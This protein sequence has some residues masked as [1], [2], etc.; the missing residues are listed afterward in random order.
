MRRQ[1]VCGYNIRL[2]LARYI[3]C[4]KTLCWHN[5]P[6]IMLLLIVTSL[7]QHSNAHVK[8][9]YLRHYGILNKNGP[10]LMKPSV[11]RLVNK[12]LLRLSPCGR[13][14]LLYRSLRKKLNVCYTSKVISIGISLASTQLYKLSPE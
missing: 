10:R 2:L 9:N 12:R 11:H 4:A 1:P 5:E 13:A 3:N 14:S 6:K 7:P 8:C